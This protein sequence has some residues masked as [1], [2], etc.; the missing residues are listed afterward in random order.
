MS[1]LQLLQHALRA[2]LRRRR[3][4]HTTIIP[5]NCAHAL[6]KLHGCCTCPSLR[7]LPTPCIT[8]HVS[9]TLNHC[10]KL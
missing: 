8:V 7:T 9:T 3:E 4:V 6:M 10:N 5:Y 1:Q 2:M